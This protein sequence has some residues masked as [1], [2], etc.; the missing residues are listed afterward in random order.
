MCQ[1]QSRTYWPRTDVIKQCRWTDKCSLVLSSARSWSRVHG[2]KLAEQQ[3]CQLGTVTKPQHQPTVLQPSSKHERKFIHLISKT[4]LTECSSLN[5]TNLISA[6]VQSTQSND[7]ILSKALHTLN[8]SA[9]VTK[10]ATPYRQQQMIRH[11]VEFWSIA[12]Q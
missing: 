3:L 4:D 8:Y 10:L 6:K 2:I 7:V 12:W 11:S 5:K 9:N 1:S